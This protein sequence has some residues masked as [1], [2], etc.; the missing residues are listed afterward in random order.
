V[1]AGDEKLPALEAEPETAALA[2][3]EA[4]INGKLQSAR[5]LARQN[6]AVVAHIVRGWVSGEQ[7]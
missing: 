6:P 5:E 4:K 7:A 1:V 3:E 2:L